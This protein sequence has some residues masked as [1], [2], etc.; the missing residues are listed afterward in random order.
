MA[1]LTIPLFALA[2]AALS[3]CGGGNSPGAADGATATL[4]DGAVGSAFVLHPAQTDGPSNRI[5]LTWQG[6]PGTFTVFVQRASG[7]AF[8]A[9]DATIMGRTAVFARGA[10]WRYDFPT[11]QV[12]VRACDADHGCVDSNTQPLLDALLAGIA[13]V[14][15][16]QVGFNAGFGNQV[17][18]SDDGHT[19]SA[20][21]P[22]DRAG[23]AALPGIGSN[24]VFERGGHGAWA[25][26]ARLERFAIANHF[27]E[28]FAL[29]G[30]GR[31]LAVGAYSDSGTQGG[32]DAPEVGSLPD[33]ASGED[34]W[35]GAVHVY[36]RDAQQS[37]QRQ[38]FIKAATPLR[39][40][41]FGFRLALSQDGNRLLVGAAA[42]MVLF[43]RE[44]GVW[45]E[46]HVFTSPQEATLAPFDGGVVLSADG[47]SIAVRARTVV[48]AGEV[49]VPAV[50]VY[51]PCP[52][53]E[54]WRRVADLRSAKPRV[55]PGRGEHDDNFG[56]S[57][58][59]SHD[60]RT[61]AVGAPR[62][63]GDADDS[64]SGGFVADDIGAVYLF[65][66]DA[67]GVWQRRA[68]LKARAARPRDNLGVEVALSGDGRVLAASAC[69]RSAHADGVRRNH[70]ADA[71]VGPLA[72]DPLCQWGGS[73]YVFEADAQGN[74]SH[75]AAAIAL[76]G[77]KVSFDP[78]FSL[79]LSA[80]AQTLAFGTM[81]FS[82]AGGRGRVIVF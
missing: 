66:P 78:S 23:D 30:D 31:T 39:N 22:N 36:T 53:G 54:G 41:L 6:A 26:Q 81:V 4:G 46:V 16:Q 64:G 67:S 63:P 17:A 2:L 35:R 12:R 1:K 15:P 75:T 45:R 80:D 40:E 70:S 13:R 82:E 38:A 20:A 32:I 33:P 61:L 19:L 58:A 72:D 25:Q 43:Q 60:G 56:L 57:M 49:P 76:P 37:W 74:W 7:Q 18:L 47:L 55:F 79:A 3:G 28:P 5:R 8:D 14:E 42:R 9:V 50:F 44:G 71:T 29:S 51:R 27:G 10:A 73:A 68:F 48:P 21:A 65:G 59:L 62:D 52:C 69:G 11:A 77:E 34:D 24:F